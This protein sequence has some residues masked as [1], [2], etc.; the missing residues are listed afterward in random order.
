MTEVD[1]QAPDVA[2]EA[3]SSLEDVT[4]SS[5]FGLTDVRTELVRIQQR[6]RRGRS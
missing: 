3:L 2:L 6:R 4:T 1:D 5:I